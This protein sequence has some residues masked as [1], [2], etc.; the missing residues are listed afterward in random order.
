MRFF[1]VVTL[2]VLAGMVAALGGCAGD[3]D[4]DYPALLTMQEMDAAVSGPAVKEGDVSSADQAGD[5][6][7]AANSMQ[8]R[9]DALR[10][11]HVIDAAL[12]DKMAAGVSRLAVEDQD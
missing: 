8:R 6:I 11:G 3:P 9:A 4:A 10:G 5:L 1:N 2:S 12:R 7:S